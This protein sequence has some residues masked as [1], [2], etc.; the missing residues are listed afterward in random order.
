MREY[1]IV[2]GHSGRSSVCT[3]IVDALLASKLTCYTTS[4][5]VSVVCPNE[6]GGHIRNGGPRSIF[7]RRDTET[8]PERRNWEGYCIESSAENGFDCESSGLL[9]RGLQQRISL[10]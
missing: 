9:S 10:I 8:Y 6:T 1:V 3:A 4:P 2:K 5:N 7:G